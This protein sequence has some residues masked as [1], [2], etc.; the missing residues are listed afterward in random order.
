MSLIDDTYFINDIALPS[1][2]YSDYSDM[3]TRFE[4]EFLIKAFGYDL[5][6]LINV[7][8]SDNPTTS[9]QRIR[10]IVEGKE[11]TVSSYTYK[12]EGLINSQ[13]DSP[14]AYYVYCQIMLN[15]QT[16][17]TTIGENALEYEN[18]QRANVNAKVSRA[19]ARMKEQLGEF[20]IYNIPAFGDELYNNSLFFFMS[21][22]WS[23]YP[24]WR[25]D[26]FGSINDFDL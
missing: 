19:W 26:N 21:L 12:W 13:K 2:T 20:F 24:E 17:T 3:I 15:N 5:Y 10:D 6:K 9:S 25:W 16:H 11:F 7:Y 23:T 8:D 18:A 22:N 4:R 1:N 14:I